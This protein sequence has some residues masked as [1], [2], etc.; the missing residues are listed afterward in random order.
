[1]F[2][3]TTTQAFWILDYDAASAWQIDCGKGVYFG[4]SFWNE[5]LYV[6]ARQARVGGNRDEQDNVI[7]RYKED[8]RLDCMIK[9]PK[10][11]RDAH[12][13]TAADGVLYV[14]S[15][16][17]DEIACYEIE[18]GVWTFWQPFK[19]YSG[20]GLDAHHINSI[21]VTAD[22]IFLAELRPRGW[23]ARFEQSTRKLISRQDL[24][25]GTHNVWL[26][27]GLIHVCS[28]NDCTILREDRQSHPLPPRAWARGYCTQGQRQFVGASEILSRASRAFSNCSVLELDKHYKY[29]GAVRLRG[30][31]MLHEIRS[32]D[33]PDSISHNGQVFGLKR[34]SLDERFI[35]HTLSIGSAS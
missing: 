34:S 23:V 2:A 21:F 6:A 20:L 11:I 4:I 13:I 14:A 9:P 8:L 33:S 29:M 24:G 3:M 22:E 31:G 10:P 7:L 27:G 25:T 28:S 30:L 1:M 5:H 26:D 19:P 17:D 16:Y 18:T 32:L 12:Q 35:K 15:S